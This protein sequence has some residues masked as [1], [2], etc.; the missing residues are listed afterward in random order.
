MVSPISH[1]D[2]ARGRPVDRPGRGLHLDAWCPGRPHRGRSR[3]PP[4]RRCHRRKRGGALP[5]RCATRP[6]RADWHDGG[7]RPARAISRTRHH[8]R[9]QRDEPGGAGMGGRAPQRAAHAAGPP[10]LLPD[11]RAVDAGGGRMPRCHDAGRLCILLRERI[12]FSKGVLAHGATAH[13][14]SGDGGRDR[15]L[16][17][18]A[19]GA[20]SGRRSC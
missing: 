10:R 9:A 17:L 4:C 3:R 15:P 2:P 19:R 14:R 18:H 6:G 20:P 16:P 11:A 12:L 1:A 5:G 13:S 8:P 7:A